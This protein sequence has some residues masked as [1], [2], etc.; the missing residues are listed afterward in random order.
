VQLSASIALV[1]VTS[2]RDH[3]RAYH[4][5]SSVLVERA[6]RSARS[7]G[8]SVDVVAAAD[9]AVTA[10]LARTDGAQ[11]IVILG[12]EDLAPEFYGGGRGYRNEGVHAER[13]DEAQIA[14]VHRALDRGT[15]LVGVCRGLQVIDVA[16]GGSLIQDLGEASGHRN[17]GV[18]VERTMADHGVQLEPGTRLAAALGGRVETRSAHHQ[19]VDALGAGLRVAARADDGLIEAVEHVTAPIVGVQWHPE[20]AGSPAAQLEAV[21]SLL[22][23]PVAARIAA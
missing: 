14:V 20:D 10:T 13:A 12:G 15:P 17:D 2:R 3:A 5:Y 23:T 19:A 22:G 7:L 18:P 9:D 21:L 8:W 1:T 6:A 16:L 4:A 11:A